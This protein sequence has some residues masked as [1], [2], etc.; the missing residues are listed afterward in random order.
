VNL[1]KDLERLGRRALVALA[2]TCLAIPRRTIT[3][4]SHPHFLVVR[5]DERLGNLLLLT[6]LLTSLRLRFPQG[7]ITVL[8]NG[9][10]HAIL[11]THPAVSRFLPFTKA[12]I[13]SAAGPFGTIWRLRRLHCDVAIDAANP[14]DPSVTQALLV[15]FSGAEHTIGPDRSWFGQLYSAPAKI[16]EGNAHEIDLRLQLLGPLPGN[17]QT[18]TMSVPPLAAGQAVRELIAAL[19]N[20][21]FGIVNVGARLR[22]KQ[23]NTAQFGTVLMALVGAGL[24]PVVVYGP[25]EQALATALGQFLPS[26]I[27]APPTGIGDLAE[28]MKA[29]RV[30]VSCDT[31]PMHLAVA[32]GTPTCGIFLATDPLRYGHTSPPHSVVDARGRATETWLPELAQWLQLW[33]TKHMASEQS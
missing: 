30:V 13:F 7:E 26:A 19:Q 10:G 6:P 11:A 33:C 31:G 27:I 28:L 29:A 4:D 22:A 25:G 5:L 23:L 9:R 15:R 14:T 17:E 18:R 2:S 3:L 20:T 24:R 21:P 32:L 1:I 12:A 16:T 8:A